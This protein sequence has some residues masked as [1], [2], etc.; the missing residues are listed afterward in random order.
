G[1]RLIRRVCPSCRL[2]TAVTP[3]QQQRFGLPGGT[4]F[5]A[6]S[7]SAE[8]M[9]QASVKQRLCRQCH[10]Y[11]YTGVSGVFE[12]VPIIASLQQIIRRPCPAADLR[13]AFQQTGMTSL[14][15]GAIALVGEGV[16][17]LEEINRV[18]P[19]LPDNL[20]PVPT[21]NAP[22][23]EASISPQVMARLQSL[24]QSVVQLNQSLADLKQVIVPP[25]SPS[26]RADPPPPTSKPS[27]SSPLDLLPEL[28]A[29]ENLSAQKR[30][31]KDH[32]DV[33]DE[34]STL[35]RDF[36]DIEELIVNDASPDLDPKDVTLVGEIEF[37]QGD[38]DAHDPFKTAMDPW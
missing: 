32:Y 5:Q 25:L 13:L 20:P 23:A 18:F 6:N 15:Q 37:P 9:Q 34:E 17:T 12:M 19:K 14:A 3:E 33:I 38:G 28:E 16:T 4:I 11:G 2:K 22:T 35:I 7:L 1:Q 31:Q 30:N 8:V 36:A 10:G 29:L 27:R 24:E 26:Q 21:I